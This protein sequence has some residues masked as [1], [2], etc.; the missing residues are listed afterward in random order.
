MGL[1]GKM[2]EIRGSL[3]SCT[4]PYNSAQRMFLRF[5]G[6]SSELRTAK[7]LWG[8]KKSVATPILPENNLALRE[9]SHQIIYIFDPETLLL[10]R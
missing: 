8:R 10:G 6:L 7:L 4:K 2:P 5:G 1:E 9:K 3:S